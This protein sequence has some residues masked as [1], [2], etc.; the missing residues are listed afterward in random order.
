MTIW[1]KLCALSIA[2]TL[3]GCGGGDSAR[4]SRPPPGNATADVS[5]TAS[6][7]LPLAVGGGLADYRMT[8]ANA[9]P[10]AASDVVLTVSV[11]GGQT[12]G[13]I[14]CAASGG[15]VCPPALG[16]SMTVPSLPKGGTLTFS[17]PATIPADTGTFS[18]TLTTASQ[19]DPVTSNNAATA[20]VAATARNFVRLTSEPGDY[21]GIGRTY[22]YTQANALLNVTAT[23]GHLGIE[24]KGDEFWFGD[25]QL[26]QS[27]SQLAAGRY[28]NLTRYPF[29][30]PADGGLSWWGEGRGCNALTGSLAI[31]RATYHNG[32]L[33]EIDLEFEQHCEGMGPALRGW[34][35]WT[36]ADNTVPPGPL[37]PPPAGLWVPP[38]GATPASGNYV[39]LQSDFGDYV[40][41]GNT[42]L[43]TPA[44][45]AIAVT[46][47]GS[48]LSL[49]IDAGGLWTADFQAM[50]GVA[51]LQPGYYGDLRRYPFH[52]PAKGGLNFTGRG[53]G[54]NQLTGWFVVDS[55]R[56]VNNALA[57]IDLRF[58]QHCEGAVPALRGR[59]RWTN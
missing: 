51:Q 39:Y 54:C 46:F 55:I 44:N 23:G 5:V 27:F 24:V 57:A 22:A 45:A 29:H 36:R 8:V 17:I 42:Y 13:T 20:S 33:L 21:I 50:V 25:F 11:D 15:A 56:V 32:A 3:A 35:H 40:G 12:L 48:R 19:G 26:P 43:F 9:G 34:I 1:R 58:E 37:V 14:A 52:N 18:A 16:P 31:T 28:A 7:L 59:V 38:S 41:D 47:A 2:V 53:A 10:D 49:L 4:S 30:A 6:A